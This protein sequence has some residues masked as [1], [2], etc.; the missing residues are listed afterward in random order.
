M[1]PTLVENSQ[2][3][4]YLFV[5]FFVVVVNTTIIMI[6]IEIQYRGGSRGV[7]RVRGI[8]LT[9]LDKLLK[10]LYKFY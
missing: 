5:N 7:Q 10:M 6:V 3:L 4:V 1:V 2:F 8:L 9:S